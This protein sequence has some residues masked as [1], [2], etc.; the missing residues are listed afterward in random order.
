MDSAIQ[1]SQRL[2]DMLSKAKTQLVLMHPFFGTALLYRPIKW[3]DRVPTAGMTVRGSMFINPAWAE[4]N[5]Q[6]HRQMQFLLAHECMHFMLLHGMRRGARD[7]KGWNYAADAVIND[8]LVQA[9]VGEFIDGGVEWQ[10]AANESTEAIYAKLPKNDSG[11]D[12]SGSGSGQPGNEPGGIGQDIIEGD[13][14]GHAMSPAELAEIEQDVRLEVAQA[15]KAAKARGDVPAGLARLIDEIVNVKT[16]W[17]DALERFFT[18]MVKEG[19]SWQRPNR[20]MLASGIVL[21]GADRV[22]KMGKVV[23]GV[24][25]SGSIGAEELA[26]FQGHL[27]RIMEQCTPEEVHVVYC[28]LQIAGVDVFTCEQ[29]PVKFESVGGGGGTSF[30]P[31]FEYITEQ[32][33]QPDALVYLTD[34]YGDQDHIDR[35]GYPVVWCST[36]NIDT[37]PF[38]DVLSVEVV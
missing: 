4:E 32:G 28:D 23:V 25:T 16:P 17:Y 3:S 27:N 19:Y 20:R 11:G 7:A 34:M 35:P 5:I 1:V 15:A 37:A 30:R 36:S 13:D 26:H 9:G 29:L 18:G 31:V 8:T 10:G 21:P 2:A 24:D 12:D 14:N 33:I 22:P 6:N 38:G